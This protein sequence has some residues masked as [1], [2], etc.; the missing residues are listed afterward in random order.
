MSSYATK[1]ILTINE[2]RVALGR[3]PLADAA[4]N[5]PMVLTGSGYVPLGQEGMGKT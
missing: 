4:A 3:E 1:G 5:K 2:A